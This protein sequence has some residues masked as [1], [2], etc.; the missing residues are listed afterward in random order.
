MDYTYTYTKEE[1]V[2]AFPIVI[3]LDR[4]PNVSE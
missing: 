1:L 3:A 4:G 2:F